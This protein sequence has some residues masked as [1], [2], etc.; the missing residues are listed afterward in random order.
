MK[1]DIWSVYNLIWIKKNNEWKTVFRSHYEHFKYLI[2]SFKL[3][4]TLIMF[5]EYIN[6]IL[7]EYLN[8]FYIIYIDD[9]L[10]Y[11]VS[12]KEHIQHVSWVLKRL[13]KHCLYVKLSKC[14]FHTDKVS[15]IR[16]IL[17]FDRVLMKKSW[18]STVKDWLMLRSY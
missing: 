11:S 18:V 5:Q 12:E 2:M 10:I 1:L 16:F 3:T 6:K 7:V 9:I 15:F 8:D 4:N 13:Q 14:D 17:T